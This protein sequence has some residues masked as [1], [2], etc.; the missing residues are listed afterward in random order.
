M[1]I[2]SLFCLF[3]LLIFES[4]PVYAGSGRILPSMKGHYIFD[5]KKKSPSY[6][7][8]NSAA[9]QLSPGKISAKSKTPVPQA[10]GKL[11]VS[12]SRTLFRKSWTPFFVLL[13]GGLAVFILAGAAL[14]FWKKKKLEEEEEW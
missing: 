12:L 9:T 3:C 1:N 11:P 2:L 10:L 4:V 7:N 13:G 14:Y 6:N 5:Y 8:S